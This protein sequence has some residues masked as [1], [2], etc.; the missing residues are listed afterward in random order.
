MK[1]FRNYAS[2]TA[3]M[4]RNIYIALCEGFDELQKDF[5]GVDKQEMIKYIMRKTKG[6]VNPM[7]L[8]MI[9]KEFEKY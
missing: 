2:D 4:Y 6:H 9:L 8:E 3:I 5:N 1:V 7:Q